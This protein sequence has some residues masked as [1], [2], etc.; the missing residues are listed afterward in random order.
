[1]EPITGL[2]K[3]LVASPPPATL[4]L[5]LHEQL[6]RVASLAALAYL[7]LVLAV[8][9]ELFDPVLPRGTTGARDKKEKGRSA[10]RIIT[11]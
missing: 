8:V 6:A 7:V 11:E 1:M 5:L 2:G 3:R 10:S 9:D 4:A